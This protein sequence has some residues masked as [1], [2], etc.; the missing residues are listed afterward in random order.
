MIYA[1]FDESAEGDSKNGLLSVSGYALDAKGVEG[2]TAEWRKML[3]QYRLPYFHMNE[4]NMGNGIFKHLHDEECDQ[5]A[6]KAISIARRHTLHG[7]TFVLNQ[8]EYRE[9]LQNQGFDCDP[10][11]FMVWS[12][13][14]QV[15]KWVH[16]NC[17]A[18][19]ILLNFENGYKTQPRANELLEVISQDE[20]SGKN[21]LA[22]HQF[23][24]KSG[25]EPTQAAD[26][27]AWHVRRGYQSLKSGKKI[28]PDTMALIKNKKILTIEWTAEQLLSISEDFCKKSGNLENAAK[29]IFSSDL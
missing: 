28:R 12:A 14:I 26:L 8:T 9:I 6:R 15:N 24:S 3:Q 1:Y 16:E 11:T 21:H 27:I 7:H 20:W 4:C 13:F 5:C 23:V 2:L 22:G 29:A 25:S 19:R 10:Y 18:E 17:P